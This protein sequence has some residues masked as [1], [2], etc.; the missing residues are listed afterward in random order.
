MAYCAAGDVQ[1]LLPAL[2]EASDQVTT[3]AMIA[4]AI[5]DASAL[6]DS[7]L[8]VRYPVPFPNPTPAIIVTVTSTLAA[9]IV[10]RSSLSA[11]GEDA[12]NPLSVE[13]RR[14]AQAIL[15]KLANGK[16]GIPELLGNAT[17]ETQGTSVAYHSAYGQRPR[18]GGWTRI[19]G[20]P[21]QS[22]VPGEMGLG[23]G[24][25]GNPGAYSQ[26]PLCNPPGPW[27]Y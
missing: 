27:C 19:I 17:E 11:G 20:S 3:S 8:C 14:E 10:C 18:S 24:Y 22:F 1:G 12:S 23:G 15:D 7:E 25:N 5:S 9:S 6:V 4:K 13:L 16:Q 2:A 21:D 26:W